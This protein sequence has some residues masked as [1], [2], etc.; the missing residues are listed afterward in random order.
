MPYSRF[1]YKVVMN[2]KSLRN[3]KLKIEKIPSMSITF[4]IKVRKAQKCLI[5]IVIRASQYS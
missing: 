1:C 5:Y 3:F 4:P 2:V